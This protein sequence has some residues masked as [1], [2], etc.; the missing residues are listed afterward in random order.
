MTKVNQ[1]KIERIAEKDFE[2]LNSLFKEFAAFEKLPEMMTNT[3]EQMKNEK[4]FFN[5]F[6]VKEE[7]DILGY[8]TFFFAY[9]TWAG[10]SLYMDDLYIRQEY[11]GQGLGTMLIKNVISFAKEHQCNKLRWQV[12]NWNEPAIKFYES[13]GAKIN[14]VEI[15]CDIN[16]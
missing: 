12:S 9:Y 4:D 7:N 10:K 16:L 5:G 3:V 6:V 1:I 13:L 11:R 14:H 2:T 8:V 15:N